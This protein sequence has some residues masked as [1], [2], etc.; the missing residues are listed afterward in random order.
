MATT[1]N[2]LTGIIVFLTN[3]GPTI[4]SIATSVISAASVINTTIPA[5]APGTSQ[6]ALKK[7]IN[8][9]SVGFAH[10]KPAGLVK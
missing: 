10:A 8:A 4:V 2:I 7:L 1:L 6:A 5:G 9:L 3:Y